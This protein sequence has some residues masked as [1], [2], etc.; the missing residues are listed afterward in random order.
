MRGINYLSIYLILPA[1][2]GTGVY[3]ASNKIPET[4]KNI[5]E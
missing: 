5:V 1:T 2:L 3:T 4:R